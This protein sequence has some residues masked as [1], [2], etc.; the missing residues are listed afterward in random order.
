[1]RF[2]RAAALFLFK[3]SKL[4]DEKFRGIFMVC[5]ENV[6]RHPYYSTF[7][8]GE[9]THKER[10]FGLSSTVHNQ[11][12]EFEWR[13]TNWPGFGRRPRFTSNACSFLHSSPV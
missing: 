7:M 4:D 2:L 13:T 1:M 12:Y 10:Q 6:R 11:Y 5:D 9:I 8:L 3:V